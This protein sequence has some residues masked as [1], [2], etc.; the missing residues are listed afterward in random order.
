MLLTCCTFNYADDLAFQV[1][2]EMADLSILETMDQKTKYSGIWECHRLFDGFLL[3]K[4]FG[5]RI[6]I[7]ISLFE[8]GSVC[9]SL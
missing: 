7:K 2:W 9:K 3:D 1:L 4:R 8:I 5:N 6:Q